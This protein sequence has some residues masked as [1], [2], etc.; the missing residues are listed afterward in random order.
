MERP[1][2]RIR[3]LAALVAADFGL[4]MAARAFLRGSRGS[5]PPLGP[6]RLG[7]VENSSGFGFDQTRLLA[8]SGFA[9][10]DSF[11]ACSLAVLLLLAAAIALWRRIRLRAWVKAL[12]TAALYF[13]SAYFAL[14]ICSSLRLELSPYARG[15]LRALGPLAVA[16]ALYVNVRRTYFSAL[17]TLFMAG[18]IGNCGSMLLPPF[19]VIDYFGAYRSS[20]GGYVYANAADLFLALSALGLLLSP[21]WLALERA[22]RTRQVERAAANAV[23]AEAPGA[24]DSQST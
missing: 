16:V 3:A 22:L 4:K 8:S 18:T 6:F 21:L 1:S 11:V 19:A 20:I 17:A 12:A 13:A 14:S 7:Y 9:I 2:A 15:L 24:G 23:P 5:C 10:D